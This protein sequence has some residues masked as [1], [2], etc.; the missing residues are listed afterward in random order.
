VYVSRTLVYYHSLPECCLPLSPPSKYILDFL[1]KSSHSADRCNPYSS[2]LC[3]WNQSSVVIESLFSEMLIFWQRDTTKVIWR[4]S[5]SW[6]NIVQNLNENN[7][8]FRRDYWR[9]DGLARQKTSRW[10]SFTQ[11][12]RPTNSMHPITWGFLD[13]TH[14]Y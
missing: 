4:W 8:N 11:W 5:M 12:T 6:S 13:T 7:T 1:I 3:A 14:N 2:C 10:P 9:H